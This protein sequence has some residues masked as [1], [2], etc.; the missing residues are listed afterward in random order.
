M[1]GFPTQT[2]GT[3]TNRGK[4]RRYTGK[5]IGLEQDGEMNSPLQKREGGAEA[6]QVRHDRQAGERTKSRSLD[7]ARDDRLGGGVMSELLRLRSLRLRSGQAGQAPLRPP[8]EQSGK[9]RD[10]MFG[11]RAKESQKRTEGLTHRAGPASKCVLFI[12]LCV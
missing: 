2:V 11:Y 10:G 1:P 3:P 8:R 6:G 12:C 7:Y 9:L 5:G 4:A